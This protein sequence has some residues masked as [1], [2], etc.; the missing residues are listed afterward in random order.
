MKSGYSTINITVRAIFTT[1]PKVDE[2]TKE[3]RNGLEQLV[4]LISQLRV[5]PFCYVE[6]AMIRNTILS[7]DQTKSMVLALNQVQLMKG[8]DSTNTLQVIFSFVC[9]NYHPYLKTWEYKRDLVYPVSIKDPRESR[10]WKMMYQAGCI[11][12]GGSVSCLRTILQGIS[13]IRKR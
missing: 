5:V 7:G 13:R 6:N 2:K 9:F 11:R 1:T 12:T 3:V 4:D 8:Q 10:M